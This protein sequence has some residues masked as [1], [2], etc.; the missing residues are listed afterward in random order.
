[1]VSRAPESDSQS[2]HNCKE[3]HP[4]S[5]LCGNRHEGLA[6]PPLQIPALNH[7]FGC[8]IAFMEEADTTLPAEKCWGHLHL[9]SSTRL[10]L[11]TAAQCRSGEVTQLCVLT[12]ALA[13]DRNFWYVRNETR[14]LCVGVAHAYTTEKVS[15]SLWIFKASADA[16]MPHDP[17][18]AACCRTQQG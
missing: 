16:P 18:F 17:D 12:A 13:C 6:C 2:V 4:A 8:S 14:Q 15:Q 1:M 9:G 5:R 7:S 10:W 11:P 3:M